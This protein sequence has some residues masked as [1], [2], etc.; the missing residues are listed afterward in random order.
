MR[1][2]ILATVLLFSVAPSAWADRKVALVMAD[3]DYKVIRPLKNAVNDGRAIQDA[4]EKLGFEVFSETNR[5]LRRM[6][7][8]LEDFREDGKDADGKPV[9]TWEIA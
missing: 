3:D 8:A 4:L 6:R 2:I 7:R 5:D 1:R 9:T